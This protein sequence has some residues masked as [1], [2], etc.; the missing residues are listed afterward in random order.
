MSLL[1]RNNKKKAGKVPLRGFG[2]AYLRRA[3]VG[4]LGV[5]GN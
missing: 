5:S 3:R 2:L 1:N 4:L